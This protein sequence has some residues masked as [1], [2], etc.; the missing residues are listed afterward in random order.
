MKHTHTT[1]N[2][3]EGE[4]YDATT[5]DFRTTF[6]VETTTHDAIGCTR[7]DVLATYNDVESARRVCDALTA[8][9][10]GLA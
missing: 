6:Q 8:H 5:R 3:I 2:V 7:T 9:A 4:R 10:G 1:Y